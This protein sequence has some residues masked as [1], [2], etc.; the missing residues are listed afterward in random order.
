MSEKDRTAVFHDCVNTAKR[1]GLLAKY[2]L[3]MRRGRGGA[4]MGDRKRFLLTWNVR[5]WPGKVAGAEREPKQV[6]VESPEALAERITE[7]HMQFKR[8][9][10]R[11]E[12]KGQ[13]LNTI[14]SY[15]AQAILNEFEKIQTY[16]SPNP[17]IFWRAVKRLRANR[18]KGGG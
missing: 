8:Q 18:T 9:K 6:V 2:Q 3:D 14:N 12:V 13:V 5:I 1:F 15:G 11:H 16:G 7:W 10:P 17:Y 4:R